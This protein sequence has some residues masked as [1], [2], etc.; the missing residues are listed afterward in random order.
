MKRLTTRLR[1]KQGKEVRSYEDPHTVLA[2][3]IKNRHEPFRKGWWQ[4]EIG[5]RQF[6]VDGP[7]GRPKTGTLVPRER[8]WSETPSRLE[9]KE[10]L[11]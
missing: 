2:V 9:E 1:K 5:T 8:A 11:G 10:E 3:G 4:Q 7:T 6:K